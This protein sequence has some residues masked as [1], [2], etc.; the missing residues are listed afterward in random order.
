MISRRG[1]R[2]FSRWKTGIVDKFV[3]ERDGIGQAV[4][5]ST[6]RKHHFSHW[7]FYVT[8]NDLL[9]SMHKQEVFRHI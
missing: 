5:L 6:Q 3:S 4:R 8:G 1:Q 2:H 9:Q 7:S